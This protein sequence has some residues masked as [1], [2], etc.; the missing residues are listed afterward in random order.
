MGHRTTLG[1]LRAV[2][3]LVA[4]R[5]RRSCPT[6]TPALMTERD[7]AALREVNVSMGIML[8]TA[9]E[10]LLGPGARP[11]PRAR[12]GAGAAAQDHRARRQARIPFT[13][14]ILIGI[15][16]T[17]A[18]RV[19]A[20][21]AIRDLHE[22]HGHIQEVIVQ[23]FRAKPTIPMR[24]CG[25]ALARGPRCA[26]SPWPGSCSARDD[27][28]PGAAEPVAPTATARLLAAGL[29][30]WGGISPLTPDHINPERPVAAASPSSG[31]RT[32]AAGLALP[33]AARDLSRVRVRG[34]SSW[35]DARLRA[36]RGGAA[37]ST[38]TGS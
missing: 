29:N 13:T 5:S 4:R 21:L 7:L 23:N 33:R 12:Q 20:L 6:P 14:G 34:R 9:S 31:A 35:T 24:G 16:E 22:R 26:R 11:R 2:C 36:A 18:E 10:R 3:A 8:E 30:D 27:E 28:H 32:E 17:H 19:D 37:R 1:Y 38:P 15:G 25:R